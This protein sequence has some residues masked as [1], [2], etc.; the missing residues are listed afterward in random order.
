VIILF[1]S[2]QNLLLYPTLHFLLISLQNKLSH[3]LHTSRCISQIVAETQVK[4]RD[5]NKLGTRNMPA[6][7]F[8]IHQGTQ[9][10]GFRDRDDNRS[11]G[12][13]VLDRVHLRARPA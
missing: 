5:P 9:A 12:N 8:Q 4:K 2:S 10:P 6:H 7:L 1:Q 11:E 3:N 13:E